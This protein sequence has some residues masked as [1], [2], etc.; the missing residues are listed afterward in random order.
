DGD[1]TMHGKTMSVALDFAAWFQL[2]YRYASRRCLTRYTMTFLAESSIS[3]E[4]TIVPDSEAMA[5]AS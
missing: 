5:F 4:D 2:G 1:G 3:I